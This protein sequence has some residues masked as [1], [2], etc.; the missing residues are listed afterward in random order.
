MA[1]EVQP[2][3]KV[4]V[5]SVVEEA[6]GHGHAGKMKGDQVVPATR[7]SLLMSLTHGLVL[8]VPPREK[9]DGLRPVARLPLAG[10]HDTDLGTLGGSSSWA[11]A[12]TTWDRS[13]VPARRRSASG[14]LSSGRTGT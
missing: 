14:T 11:M 9:P 5:E 1:S 6:N 4:R 12:S 7:P 10:G 8:A 3:V 13:W 2:A